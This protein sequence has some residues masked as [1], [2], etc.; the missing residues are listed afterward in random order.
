MKKIA[1]QNRVSGIDENQY[2]R[3]HPVTTE[4]ISFLENAVKNSAYPQQSQP[5][6][7]F[8]RI[9]AKLIAF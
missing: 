3:T 9:K 1:S 5:S 2:F 4:R 6:E 8:L 7:A